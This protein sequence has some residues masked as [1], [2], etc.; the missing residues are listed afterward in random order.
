M[1]CY[2]RIIL[3]LLVIIAIIAA[4]WAGLVIRSPQEKGLRHVARLASNADI[5][6]FANNS[7]YFVVQNSNMSL[8]CYNVKGDLL[9]Q[10]NIHK[11]IDDFSLNFRDNKLGILI[12]DPIFNNNTHVGTNIEFNIVDIDT[13]HVVERQHLAYA[14]KR[15][16]FFTRCCYSS[17]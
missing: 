7:N 14:P 17:I 5:V 10:I 9:K 12:S 6:C 4:Y 11:H 2:K 13:G 15:L 16:S 3:L 8:C 1:F